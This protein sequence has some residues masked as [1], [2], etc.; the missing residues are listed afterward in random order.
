MHEDNDS[1]L[2]LFLKQKKEYSKGEKEPEID[3]ESAVDIALIGATNG[4]VLAF[5]SI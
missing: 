1:D 3:F 5:D 4:Q 2:T